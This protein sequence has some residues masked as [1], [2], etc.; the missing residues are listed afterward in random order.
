MRLWEWV[1][2]TKRFFG[3]E[4]FGICYVIDNDVTP[5]QPVNI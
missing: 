1:E 5:N 2:I 3:S 4:T